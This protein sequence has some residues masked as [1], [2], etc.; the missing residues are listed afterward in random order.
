MLS[1]AKKQ[2]VPGCRISFHSG[3]RDISVVYTV[4]TFLSL[5]TMDACILAGHIPSFSL[6][7]SR[8]HC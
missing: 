4:V 3:C 7:K 6:Y 5:T 8:E 1:T 2:V